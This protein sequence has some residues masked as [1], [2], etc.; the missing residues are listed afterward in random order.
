MNAEP[1][2]TTVPE[3]TVQEATVPVVPTAE[4]VIDSLSTKLDKCRKECK[5]LRLMNKELVKQ[6]AAFTTT[7]DGKTPASIIDGLKAQLKATEEALQMHVD[8]CSDLRTKLQEK[9]NED[10]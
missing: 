7:A 1:D 10:G 4:E 2:P 8:R 6:L 5:K 3:A 9:E